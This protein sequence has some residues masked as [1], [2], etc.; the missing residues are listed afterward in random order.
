MTQLLSNVRRLTPLRSPQ[1]DTWVQIGVSSWSRRGRSLPGRATGA[2]GVR[3]EQSRRFKERIAC[4]YRSKVCAFVSEVIF[5]LW[6]WGSHSPFVY[7]SSE[8]FRGVYLEPY[9]G[10]FVCYLMLF[11]T[12]NLGKTTT[13]CPTTGR[14]PVAHRGRSVNSDHVRRPLSRSGQL[15]GTL[16]SSESWH[17]PDPVK[18]VVTHVPRCNACEERGGEAGR[19]QAGEGE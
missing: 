10:M 16:G 11:S 5:C 13:E 18:Q 12:C 6:I 8:F 15:P 9:I 4:L 3:D 7:R 1:F 19:M 17:G 14:I 2:T